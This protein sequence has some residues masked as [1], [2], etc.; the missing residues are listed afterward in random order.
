MKLVKDKAPTGL[1]RAG[2]AVVELGR[3]AQRVTPAYLSGNAG[4]EG[5][6]KVATEVSTGRSP[7]PELCQG[8][9]P[10]FSVASLAPL[11]AA[12]HEAYQLGRIVEG[13]LGDGAHVLRFAALDGATAQPAGPSR[14]GGILT[15]IVLDRE[16]AP[17]TGQGAVQP[18]PRLAVELSRAIGQLRKELRS[19]RFDLLLTMER[20]GLVVRASPEASVVVF[21]EQGVSLGQLTNLMPDP[22]SYLNKPHAPTVTS[23]P[24][25]TARPG[26]SSK[27]ASMFDGGL[28]VLK[29]LIVGPPPPVRRPEVKAARPAEPPPPPVA[30]GELEAVTTQ[31][32]RTAEEYIGPRIL[33]RLIEDSPPRTWEWQNRRVVLRVAGAEVP[34]GEVSEIYREVLAIFKR[35]AILSDG[36][37]DFDFAS[38]LRG[39]SAVTAG[40]VTAAKK[41][42]SPSPS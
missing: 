20:G 39:T 21:V 15:T 7:A 18:S 22:A 31:L 28:A 42:L 11:G 9:L 10:A 35:G 8:E 27:K 13:Q 16:G 25:V 6:V 30:R 23:L 38:W 29:R 36:L 32:L 4:L 34:A 26:A 2:R 33:D 14:R 1:R 37:R 19:P 12:A 5:F 40:H 41:V 3:L 17:L 24:T